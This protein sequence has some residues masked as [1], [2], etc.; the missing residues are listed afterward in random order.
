MP[1]YHLYNARLTT[2]RPLP[3]LDTRPGTGGE[4]P[5]AVTLAA[6]TP[7]PAAWFH[8][9]WQDYPLRAP[10]PAFRVWRAPAPAGWAFRLGYRNKD[11]TAHFTIRADCQ[12]LWVEWQPLAIGAAETYE[13]VC[14]LL[15]GPVVPFVLRLAGQ[16]ALHGAVVVAHDCGLAFVGPSGAGKSTLATTCAQ[17][18]WPTLADD[19][20]VLTRPAD[21]FDVHPGPPSRHL[22]PATLAALAEESQ[23]HPVVHPR[24][25]KRHVDSM[26]AAAPAWSAFVRTARPLR[27][28]FLLEPFVLATAVTAIERVPASLALPMLLRNRYGLVDTPPDAR[29]AE[30]RQLAALLGQT[31]VYRTIRPDRPDTHVELV[32]LLQKVLGT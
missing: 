21:Q 14:R 12:A 29:P 30:F 6:L 20:V 16:I 5:L 25:S 23:R 18:G 4:W 7:A 24:T 22:W 8:E 15:I 27:T 1:E 17:R 3:A 19:V 31:A 28:I 10:N 9:S 11:Y 26:A 32:A 13:L 2:D